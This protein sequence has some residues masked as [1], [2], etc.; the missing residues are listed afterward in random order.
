MA[1]RAGQD[2]P[3]QD[4][5]AFQRRSW[6]IE[7]AAWGAMGLL[8]AAAVLGLLSHGPLSKT[9]A[10]TTNDPRLAVTYERLERREA[11][12]RFIIRAAHPQPT[13]EIAVHFGPAFLDAYEIR[14][15]TPQPVRAASGSGGYEGVFAASATGETEVHITGRAKRFGLVRFR[16]ETPG[17]AAI[18][19]RQFIF[20]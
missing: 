8:A 2:Y 6:L 19:V 18:N 1:A 10:S 4:D 20:P 5:M 17:G 7:R 15:M 13:R 3:I 16:I 11:S 14:T 12:S 9:T